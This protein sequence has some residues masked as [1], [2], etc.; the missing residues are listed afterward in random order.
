MM[1]MVSRE[2]TA[3][4]AVSRALKTRIQLGF[5]LTDSVPIFDVAERLGADVWFKDI[6]SLEGMYIADDNPTIILSGGRH[7]PEGRRAFTCA[8][9]LGHHVFNH[10]SRIDEIRRQG[11]GDDLEEFSADIFG[12]FMLMPQATVEGGFLRRGWSFKNPEPE[13]VY[14]VASW[15]GVGYTSLLDHMRFSLRTLSEHQHIAL[16]KVTPKRIIA[17]LT[18]ETARTV[19][20]VDKLWVGR[21][22]D[23]SV[24]DLLLIPYSFAIETDHVNCIDELS[25]MRLFKATKVGVTRLV[26]NHSNWTSFCRISRKNYMGRNM[27]RFLEE[28]DED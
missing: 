25:D 12:A 3:Q 24:E 27:Y 14:R 23:L 5:K 17:S 20:V 4:V 9:E 7:R 26:D 22:V 16:S 28:N 19:V 15:L 11:F 13:Q 8:H 1:A 6:P 18:G 2:Q 21:P 10:G